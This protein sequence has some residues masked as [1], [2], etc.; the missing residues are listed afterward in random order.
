MTNDLQKQIAELTAK[1][2]LNERIQNLLPGLKASGFLFSY[3]KRGT[4]Y[5]VNIDLIE[6][7][8]PE[9]SGAIQQV[10]N[11]FIPDRNAVVSFAGKDDQPT[12][13]PFILNWNNGVREK[14][15][16]IEYNSGEYWVKISVPV[17]YYSDDCKGVFMRHP[18]DSEYHYFPG[19]SADRIRKTELRA[20]KLD[21]FEKIGW[22]GGNVTNFINHED[23][24]EEFESVVLKGHT[25]QFAEFWQNQL[26]TL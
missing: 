22:Y 20:Y 18:S 5:S 3:K 11:A 2:E 7:P 6:T 16:N 1:H 13:S 17:N 4:E 8:L 10:L 9:I 25:P 12:E 24:R 21:M 23:D 19:M 26:K 15:A 14:H